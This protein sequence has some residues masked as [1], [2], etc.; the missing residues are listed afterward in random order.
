MAQVHT[1]VLRIAGGRRQEGTPAG[2]VVLTPPLRPAPGRE[3]E[4]FL[5]VLDLGDAPSRLYREVRESA[6][7]AFWETP[8]SV[9]AALR[10]A[11]LAVSRAVYAHNSRASP[12]ERVQ[13]GMSCAALREGELFLAQTGPTCAWLLGET[14]LTRLLP[15]DLPPLGVTAYA[16]VRISCL[17]FGPGDTLL[18]ATPGLARY[19]SDDALRRVLSMEELGAVVDGLEQIAGGEDLAA[20]V[21]RSPTKGP[22]AAE[23]PAPRR[24]R[25]AA[26]PSPLPS[27]APAREE[28]PA[29]RAV[30]S[31]PAA[32][33]EE[34]PV[35][36]WEPVV[37]EAEEEI[38]VPAWRP[39]VEPA[40]PPPRPKG[41]SL[42]ERVRPGERLRRLGRWVAYVGSVV[43]GGL[44]V[45]F[46]RAL[47]GRERG[48]GRRLRERR[49]PPPENPRVMAG[50]AIVIFLL[51][52][53]VTLVAWLTYGTAIRRQQTLD[54]ARQQADLARQTGDPA[55]A[56]A[57]WEGV[58]RTLDKMEEDPDAAD[59][60]AQ[61]QAAL[62]R[63]D[64]VVR[65]EPTLLAKLE[66]GS[67]VRRLVAYGSLLFLLDEGRGVLSQLDLSSQGAETV[68]PIPSVGVEAP[69]LV[70]MAW[71][72]AGEGWSS[73]ALVALDTAG[74]L[75]VYD[76]A[77]PDA[78]SS[79]PLGPA[80]GG[81]MPV[82]MAVFEGRLYLL[83]P[84]ADQIWRYRP[85]DGGYPDRAEPYFPTRSPQPLAGARDLAINGNI[86]VLFRDGEVVK[87]LQGE[88]VPFQ[89][90]GVPGPEPLFV[91]LAVDPRRM[92]GPVYLADGVGERVVVLNDGGRFEMQLC[93]AA[94]VFQGLRLVALDDTATRLLMVTGTGVYALPLPSSP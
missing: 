5:A 3:G 39:A 32:I 81:G 51:V 92:D 40:P 43:A 22:V 45:L 93:A 85:R 16:E 91:S 75:W 57:L 26:A 47:P 82:A 11:A 90:Q 17:D 63:M 53:V 54:Q 94:G 12:H 24:R 14:G 70:D 2:V 89:V 37:E 71:N 69:E 19:A 15:T 25:R 44:G 31:P 66:A 76:P 59:L 88:R 61:A 67:A 56:R 41:P 77:W 8:G 65:V 78:T 27:P 21:V 18:L 72:P 64:G 38:E 4:L 42:L 13:G 62:D 48:G 35:R 23:L 86:Y 60:R 80:P 34:R 49:P 68:L 87:F 10:R 33:P 58:L 74:Q 50:I 30:P 20:L 29:G 84:T 36:I 1:E 83:D 6:A 73:N 9:I 46:Q 55:Q 28:A 79:I 7:Q 52:A